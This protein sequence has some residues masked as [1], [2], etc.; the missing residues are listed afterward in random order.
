MSS[1][2][3]NRCALDGVARVTRLHIGARK[4]IARV[5]A[6][7]VA[8]FALLCLANAQAAGYETV[9]F[10]AAHLAGKTVSF[11][12]ILPRD[13]ASS[14]R[15]F[16][17]LY[18]LHG[19]TGNYTDWVRLTGIVRYARAYEEIIIMPDA[20]RFCPDSCRKVKGVFS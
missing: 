9:Q 18:L 6:L 2:W 12:L 16:P 13:Y 7:L 17:V 3:D 15:R 20:E 10:K 14:D 1:Q 5:C 8:A 11:N 4:T 19:Y